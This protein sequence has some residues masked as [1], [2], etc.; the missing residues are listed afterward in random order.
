MENTTLELNFIYKEPIFHTI[1]FLEREYKI[2]NAPLIIKISDALFKYDNDSFMANIKLI[3]KK[4]EI[5][6]SGNFDIY[7]GK[8]TGYCFLDN[9][10]GTNYQLIFKNEDIIEIKLGNNERLEKFDDFNSKYRK[11]LL[12]INFNDILS[13]NNII[14]N[15]KIFTLGGGNSYQ[16]SFY[17]IK[18]EKIVVKK[19]KEKTFLNVKEFYNKNYNKLFNFYKDLKV[20]E[21]TE[22]LQIKNKYNIMKSN[23]S[24]LNNL[25]VPAILY[26]KKYIEEQFNEKKY[27]D[28]FFYIELYKFFTQ[29]KKKIKNEENYLKESISFIEN[30]KKKLEEDNELTLFEIISIIQRFI[31]QYILSKNIDDF[32]K[33]DFKYYCLK[34]T[35]ENSVF[36]L[37][38]QYLKSFIEK[39]N[40]DSALFFPILEINSGIGF[41]NKEK[42]FCFNILNVSMIKEHLIDIIPEILYFYNKSKTNNIATTYL[43]NGSIIINKAD[44]FKN[45]NID[46]FLKKPK[47]ENDLLHYKDMAIKLFRILLHEMI[48][49]K[50][51]HYKKM[52]EETPK[53]CFDNKNNVITFVEN[54]SKSTDPNHYKILSDR[55]YK[56]DSGHYLESFL[57][58]INNDFVIKIF[59]KTEGL[60]KL[61]DDVSIFTDSNFDTLKDYVYYKKLLNDNQ[62][63]LKNNNN[64][65]IKEE[66]NEIKKLLQNYSIEDEVNKDK[67]RERDKN[68]INEEDYIFNTP[69]KIQKEEFM[70]I[71]ESDNY[72]EESNEESDSSSLYEENE[73]NDEEITKI[74]NLSLLAKIRKNPEKYS[75]KTKYKC[76]F[77]YDKYM[78]VD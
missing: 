69:K 13:I 17:D 26:C 40:E 68:Y 24:S 75:P 64:M 3:G 59:D 74:Y 56:G 70:N 44:F 11:R 57:G 32:N 43:F 33:T 39:L 46:K 37:T 25:I 1:L 41:Y 5:S 34:N 4:K 71:K 52:E 30:Y 67:K 48:G 35:E 60:G 7:F 10:N 6:F 8:N 45:E 36:S 27:I 76:W 61:I 21:N 29:K 2:T 14:F 42:F 50:Q 20:L 16:F 51:F 58:R 63:H 18:E 53:K 62:L 28:L 23:H 73:E 54:N 12:L 47:N 19:V 38:I 72:E 55:F 9:L 66:I 49:H 31:Y 65:S 15:L 22:Y 77:Y 78:N